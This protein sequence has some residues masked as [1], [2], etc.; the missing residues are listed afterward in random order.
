MVIRKH[1]LVK[2]HFSFIRSCNQLSGRHRI[3]WLTETIIFF[4]IPALLS[5]VFYF[6]VGRALAHKSRHVIRNRVLTVALFLSWLFWILCWTP[7]YLV[8]GIINLDDDYGYY[9]SFYSVLSMWVETFRIPLQLFYS[10]LNPFVYLIVLKKFQQHHVTVFK[11]IWRQL[12]LENI[13]TGIRFS[14]DKVATSLLHMSNLSKLFLSMTFIGLV[15]GLVVYHVSNT[16]MS[17]NYILEIKFRPLIVFKDVKLHDYGQLL[18]ND[19]KLDIEANCFEK[20]GFVNM[21]HKRCYI[22]RDHQPKIVDLKN[23]GALNFDQMVESCE[24]VNAHLCYPRSHEE[25]FYFQELVEN[26]AHAYLQN[27]V[28]MQVY[29]DRIGIFPNASY[30]ADFVAEFL[31][32]YRIP[33][34]FR[35]SSDK[36]FTSIDGRYNISSES[37]PWFYSWEESYNFTMVERDFHGP[38]VCLSSFNETLAECRYTVRSHCSVCCADLFPLSEQS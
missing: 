4:G 13:S 27:W 11:W 29:N 24:N 7:N 8:I 3:R 33:L 16:S 34:G 35:K 38:A 28:T 1:V 30:T 10:H 21:D 31:K 9:S 17:V 2:M 18:P 36:M 23:T 12:F 20:R 26:W 15:F 6:L 14:R 25:M 5:C 19:W 37:E 22:I 32:K